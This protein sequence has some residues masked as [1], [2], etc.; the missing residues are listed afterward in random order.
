MKQLDVLHHVAISV[1]D[2]GKAVGWYTSNFRCHIDYQDAT[3]A[4][5]RFSNTSLALVIPAQ[6]PP[7]I[8]FSSLCAEKFGELKLHRDGTRS[9]YVADPAGNSVEVMAED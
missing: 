5:L 4:L 2:I 1:D 8:A 7:H 3:W 9:V 6:H